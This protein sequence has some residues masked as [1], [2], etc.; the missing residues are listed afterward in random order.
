M[1]RIKSIVQK[2]SKTED[3]ARLLRENPKPLAKNLD[4][5]NG[6]TMALVSSDLQIVH[7]PKNPLV[8]VQTITF[9]T[10]TTITAGGA[11][12]FLTRPTGNNTQTFTFDTGLTFVAT[13]QRLED[14][15]HKDLL[16]V[17]KRAVEDRH[18]ASRLKDFLDR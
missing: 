17:T 13:P 15:D 5:S 7:S 8:P 14:L 6:E 9:I 3:G 4:L 12:A 2:I 1:D 18:F 11:G 10:G 16:E